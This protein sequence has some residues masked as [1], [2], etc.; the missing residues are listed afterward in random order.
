MRPSST[1]PRP[2]S[3]SCTSHSGRKLRNP[4]FSDSQARRQSPPRPP[5]LRRGPRARS[6]AQCSPRMP[7]QRSCCLALGRGRAPSPES[8][9]RGPQRRSRWH[10]CHWRRRRGRGPRRGLG[11]ELKTLPALGSRGL[12]WHRWR[13]RMHEVWPAW[14]WPGMAQLQP[15]LA[16]APSPVMAQRQ[17][18]LAS[19]PSSL[20]CLP[21]GA[22]TPPGVARRL[23]QRAQVPQ[24]GTAQ[25]SPRPMR[26]L[27]WAPPGRRRLQLHLPPRQPRPVPCSGPLWGRPS[28]PPPGP[29]PSLGLQVCHSGAP[30]C[31]LR[32]QTRRRRPARRAPSP[33]ARRASSLGLRQP[34]GCATRTDGRPR[35]PPSRRLSQYL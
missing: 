16:L 7:Q 21:L 15:L 35:S 12:V 28:A 6:P 24:P 29:V 14:P 31:C 11:H 20:R 30:P 33:R 19:V 10:C 13:L 2:S 1:P 5:A 22:A 4:P 32:H 26:T 27:H 23:Q 8:P 9:R 25:G 17:P 18:P 34:A 3:R